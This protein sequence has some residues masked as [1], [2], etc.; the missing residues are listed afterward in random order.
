M[1]DDRH[2]SMAEA[3]RSPTLQVKID[4]VDLKAMQHL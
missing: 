4:L 1:Y 2:P 3:Q